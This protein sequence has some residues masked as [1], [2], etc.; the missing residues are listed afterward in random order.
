MNDIIYKI[1]ENY[2]FNESVVRSFK[3]K[4]PEEKVSKCKIVVVEEVEL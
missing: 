2:F 4:H 1:K 3:K